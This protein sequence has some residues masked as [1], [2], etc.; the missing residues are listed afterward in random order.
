MM[1]LQNADQLSSHKANLNWQQQFSQ[2]AEKEMHFHL[3]QMKMNSGE[4]QTMRKGGK[5]ELRSCRL[6]ITLKA[7]YTKR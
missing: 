7:C 3:T 1:L 4:K 2:R 5:A 6:Y